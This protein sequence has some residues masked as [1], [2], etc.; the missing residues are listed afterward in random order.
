MIEAAMH[1]FERAG[2]EGCGVTELAAKAGVTTGALYHHFGSKLGLYV[3]VRGDLEK[4]VVDRMEG[5]AQGAAAAGADGSPSANRS[6]PAHE[7]PA[8]HTWT[9]GE[10]AVVRA[11]L[12]VAFDAA[13]RF[14]ACRLLGEPP[15]PG[16]GEG[17]EGG[18]RA[19]AGAGARAGAEAGPSGHPDP[20]EVALRAHLPDRLAVGAAVLV[21]GWRAALLSVA[22]GAPA[23]SAR[24]ALEF[25][26]GPP[27]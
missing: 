6:P 1:H 20:I 7:P 12:L 2:F 21:A 18:E 5:A 15:L 8:H 23:E 10:R 11:A 13:V 16:G 27:A 14:N 17:G 24:A 22:N 26:L 9:V 3:A 4:R 19:G 25:M